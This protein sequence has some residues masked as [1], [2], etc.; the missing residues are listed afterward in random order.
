[1]RLRRFVWWLACASLVCAAHGCTD[2]GP[3]GA[4]G[5]A[6]TAGSAGTGGTAGAGG[7]A[8]VGGTAGA[9][10]TG[11]ELA[12]EGRV[13]DLD[14][15]ARRAQIVFEGEVIGIEYANAEDNGTGG[16]D[17]D[18]DDDAGVLPHTFVTYSIIENFTD[19]HDEPTIT[20]R[21]MGG[22][23]PESGPDYDIFAVAQAPRFDIGD[24]DILFVTGN[25]ELACPLDRC[26]RGRFRILQS[27]RES[28]PSVFSEYGQEVRL[29]EDSR[30]E[31]RLFFI[32]EHRIPET[33]QH[34]IALPD[35]SEA[36]MELIVEDEP[37]EPQPPELLR[38]PKHSD[39][40]DPGGQEPT[41][42]PSESADA[43]IAGIRLGPNAFRTL[44]RR[45]VDLGLVWPP[46]VNADPTFAFRIG[47]AVMDDAG[48]RRD[49]DPEVDPP[50]DDALGLDEAAALAV[51]LREAC[52]EDADA[53]CDAL[54]PADEAQRLRVLRQTTTGILEEPN[55][56]DEV[57]RS[58]DMW[59]ARRE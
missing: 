33:L 53:Q 37:V 19:N 49:D 12:F 31:G 47:E 40:H 59:T 48:P 54:L 35:G 4:G 41:D 43:P 38:R 42:Q 58:E 52:G 23:D 55:E 34:T 56:E 22:V 10:G 17:P 45:T 11:G 27:P 50:P 46:A 51:A 30:D 21:F 26:S 32:G 29:L 14:V 39:A 16:S 8:G 57:S 1:M 20:L 18:D 9:G 6:G 25:T 13:P 3:D 44:V 36:S 15:A 5:S 2:D 7:T 24:R 28:A